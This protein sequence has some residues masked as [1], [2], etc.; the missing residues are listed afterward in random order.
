[1]VMTMTNN[2][3]SYLSIPVYHI[4]TD[5][6]AGLRFLLLC[7][8]TSARSRLDSSSYP[9]IARSRLGREVRVANAGVSQILREQYH[10]EAQPGAKIACPFCHHHTLSIKRDDTL[11]SASMPPVA[12]F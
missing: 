7:L 5:R 11:A 4:S 1:M 6:I 10:I 3:L 9:P 8:G 12:D 2:S